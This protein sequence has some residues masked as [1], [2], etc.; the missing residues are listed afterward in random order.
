MLKTP[1]ERIRQHLLSERPQKHVRPFEQRLA[2]R[3]DAIHLV[4]STSWPEA[5]IGTPASRVRQA[6]TASKFSIARPSGSMTRWQPA[7]D[8]DVR[9]DSILS[10]IVRGGASG[11]GSA[12]GWYIARRP[13]RRRA[14][15]ILED[16]LA[17]QHRCG[18][19]RVRG[20]HQ[21][22]AFA[23]QPAARIL[24]HRDT[25][26]VAAVHVRNAVVLG[27]P[28]VDERVVGRQQIE[29]VAILAA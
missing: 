18:T 28:L 20:D 6:P 9:W 13:G 25:A 22:A 4:P 15:E 7:H 11:A 5:S 8:G 16:P 10:R 24:G 26:E 12:S 17:A 14:H 21:Q 23:Q 2:K 3:D 1:P 29:D 27:Q 19:V